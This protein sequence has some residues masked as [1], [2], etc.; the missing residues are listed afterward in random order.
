MTPIADQ[1][2]EQLT[3]TLEGFGSGLEGD[4]R[5][6]IKALLRAL[7]GG[8]RGELEPAYHLSAIDPGIGKT[9]AVATFLK[10]WKKRGFT[11]SSSVLI[12]V[13]RLDEIQTYLSHAGL[14]HEDIAV[15]TSD[16]A[17]NAIGVTEA[18]HHQARVM[19]T[20]QQMIVSRTKGKTFEEAIEFNY[21][22]SPRVLRIWD[23]S[24]TLAV[25][26]TLRLDDLG[27]I[28]P[29]LRRSY[30][31]LVNEVRHCQQDFWDVQD[32]DRVTVSPKL[33]ARIP[34]KGL[35]KG[36][37]DKVLTTLKQLGGR[38]AAVVDVG[39]GDMILA[40]SAEPFPSDFGPVIILD[41][42]GRVRSTYRFWEEALGTLRR[43]PAAAN[44]YRRLRVHLWERKV[45]KVAF[46]E[47]ATREDVVAAVAG[48]INDAG[49]AGDWL[50]ITYKDD[51]K[52]AETALRQAVAPGSDK[53][54]HFL[55]WGRHHGTNAF[56]HCAN[57][58][59][60]GQV[61][62][63]KADYHALTSAACGGQ[64]VP[65]GAVSK[66]KA[67]EYRHHLLQA[68]TRASVRRSVNGVAGVCTAYIVTSPGNGASEA[69]HETFPGCTVEP[70]CPP[71]AQATGHA[72]RLIDLLT[73][74]GLAG[75]DTVTKAALRETLG[76]SAPNFAKLLNHPTVKAHMDRTHLRTGRTTI[77]GW[78]RFDPLPGGGWTIDELDEELV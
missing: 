53:R 35:G 67:G 20:T 6:A 27:L 10:V 65:E 52:A 76:L 15:L 12:G 39:E 21:Q 2:L 36:Q 54:L 11:P 66:L 34:S 60:I 56:A 18:Y 47:S 30:P 8:L 59:I 72:G 9:L 68:L 64:T 17:V 4:S 44:D 43:L 63:G 49:S 19:F 13:S 50:I 61:T 41:A 7:E 29:L 77:F 42:S 48:L 74:K 69:I 23:E 22:D 28:P 58:V 31:D 51:L 71:Q 33:A 1:A 46:E 57:V 62:Y 37:V 73:A 38:E 78:V 26:L 55:T 40:G 45:G 75:A 16:S 24:L 3:T 25:P 5:L 70:W 14:I 32:G